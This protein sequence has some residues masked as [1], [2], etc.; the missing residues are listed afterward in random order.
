[1]RGS[2]VEQVHLSPVKCNGAAIR[3]RHWWHYCIKQ[4]STPMIISAIWMQWSSEQ[5]AGIA[6]K[7]GLWGR[8]QGDESKQHQVT[9][10]LGDRVRTFTPAR[11][12][13]STLPPTSFCDNQLFCKS[14]TRWQHHLKG[15]GRIS[16]LDRY[17]YNFR[18]TAKQNWIIC[19]SSLCDRV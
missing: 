1:M 13:D 19:L 12:T 11:Y 16:F 4:L 9:A 8:R 6:A 17:I 18:F 15:L 7:T 2:H 5:D 3:K 14:R 10:A